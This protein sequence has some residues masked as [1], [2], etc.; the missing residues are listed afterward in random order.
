MTAQKV[1][2]K[3]QKPAEGVSGDPVTIEYDFG[4]NL[5]E[6]C[7]KFGEDVVYNRAKASFTIDL[8]AAI[9]RHIQAGK[10]PKEIQAALANWK[11]GLKQPGKSAAEKIRD[12]LKG[13]TESEKKALL[14][15]IGLL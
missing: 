4:D 11:P 2:A 6:M 1:T 14:K 15:E 7:D 12:M 10:K 5:K 8:Q 9:R 3:I 13:K